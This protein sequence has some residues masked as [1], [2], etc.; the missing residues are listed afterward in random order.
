MMKAD[1]SRLKINSKIKRY[2]A[3][4]EI[5]I[6]Y[7]LVLLIVIIVMIIIRNIQRI[8]TVVLGNYFGREDV[9]S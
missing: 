1:A 6:E 8:V 2:A 5:R 3:E 9:V 4:K 7:A